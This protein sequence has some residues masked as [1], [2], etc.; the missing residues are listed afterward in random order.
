MTPAEPLPGASSDALGPFTAHRRLLFD[1]AYRMLGS[2]VDA[3]DVLQDAW[4]SWDRADR[5]AVL[6][7]RAYLVRTVTNLSLNRLTSARATRETYIGPWL[8][9]PLLTEALPTVPDGAEEVEMAETVST[10][11]LVVLES[12]SPL[13]RAVFLLREVFG[14]AYAEIAEVLGRAEATVRQTGHRARAH[15]Q[16][17]RPRFATEP[18]QRGEV[19][20]RF[21]A[22]CAG[23]D[24]NAVM[25]L[26]A[27]EVTAWSDGGGKVT[28]ARRPLHGADHVA[29][30]LLGM[31]AKPS[32]QAVTLES[33][34]VNGEESV[35]FVYGGVAC[36]A[37]T[38]DLDAEDG[39]VVNLR[40]QVNPE[41]VAGL[42]GWGTGGAASG[43]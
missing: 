20:R 22:A 31:L 21:L 17:R 43:M 1:V 6:N 30:W 11:M 23:G 7:P 12:L 8:P 29:R 15:V 16:A 39:R 38:Y 24:L 40:L 36:A 35:V 32:L 33:A 2:V 3:E 18:E 14:Y 13:E 28:A 41:K 10:A 9:E 25:E 34:R 4:L 42:A 5:A 37:L 26:L 19:T 27:P